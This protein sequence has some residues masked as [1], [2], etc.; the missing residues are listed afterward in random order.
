M[1]PSHL[2]AHRFD[3]FEHLFTALAFRDIGGGNQDAQDQPQRIDTH[4]S[5]TPFNLFACVVSDCLVHSRSGF[6]TLAIDAAFGRARMTLLLDPDEL[7]QLVMNRDPGSVFAPIAKI[8]RF[9]NE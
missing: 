4:K 8:Q 2:F 7:A 3:F 9:S 5:F 1:Q 6:N